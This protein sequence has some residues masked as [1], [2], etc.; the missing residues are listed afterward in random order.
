MNATLTIG[1]SSTSVVMWVMSAKFLTSPHASPSGVSL[2]HS[3]PHWLGCNARGPLTL[4]VFSNWEEMRVIIP[5]A[6]IKLRRERTCVTPARSIR[7]RFSDQLPVEMARTKPAVIWSPWNCMVFQASNSFVREG[8]LRTLSIDDLRLVLKVLKRSS[9]NKAS[10]CPAL[11]RVVNHRIQ[12]AYKSYPF[13][14]SSSL[15][16]PT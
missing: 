12:I 10:S 2:G 6:E 5:N 4:R 14:Y 11:R 15:L 3:I 8:F 9:N 13:A 7:N 1:S 16:L